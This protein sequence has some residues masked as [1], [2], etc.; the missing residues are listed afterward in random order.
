[1]EEQRSDA[2][3]SASSSP[4]RLPGG[5]QW[6]GAGLRSRSPGEACPQMPWP[7]SAS[8]VRTRDTTFSNGGNRGQLWD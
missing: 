7:L 6:G 8:Q 2:L 1:M 5:W 4:S 3:G